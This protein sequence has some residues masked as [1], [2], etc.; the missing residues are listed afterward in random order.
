MLVRIR[1]VCRKPKLVSICGSGRFELRPPR[2]VSDQFVFAQWLPSTE[3]PSKLRFWHA[4]GFAG[5]TFEPFSIKHDNFTSG[6]V[7]RPLFDE[8]VQRLGEPAR[9][10]PSISDRNSCVPALRPPPLK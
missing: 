6:R 7:D 9:R 10:T 4:I 2:P 1:T 5:V 8:R 3:Q